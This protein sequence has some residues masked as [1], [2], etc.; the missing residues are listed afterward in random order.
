VTLAELMEVPLL[1]GDERL[2]EAPGA[3]CDVE[4]I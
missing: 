1:T 3:R 2:A 4:T